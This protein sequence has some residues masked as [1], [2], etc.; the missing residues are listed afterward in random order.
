MALEC[1]V[2][3]SE[4]RRSEVLDAMAAH[5]DRHPSVHLLHEDR[6]WDANRT[7]FTL[8]GDSD[9]LLQ[10]LTGLAQDCLSY[11]DMRQ[12][13]GIHPRIGALDVCPIIPLHPDAE[14]EAHRTVAALAESF[15]QLG[16][17]GWFYAQSAVQE[18]FDLLAH[19]R[20][21]DYEGVAA[22]A[23][24]FDFGRY[25]PRFGAMALG[26]RP[27]LLAYNVNVKG[28]DLAQVK[29][30]AKNV[31]ASSLGGIPG[32]RAIGWD[33][34]EFGCLQVSCNIVDLQQCTPKMLFDRI[35][36]EATVL[37]GA[38]WG[39]EL[40]G[41]APQHAFRDF[42]STEDAVNYLGLSQ[43][44]PFNPSERILERV[45]ENL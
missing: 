31:R 30:I 36:K 27:F 45:L 33:T 41:M 16:V 22:R 42:P 14:N 37:G 2:N 10:A 32:I 23:N 8:V 4:G 43:V 9:G 26:V 24:T 38:L 15:A 21:G 34:P 1:V 13:A 28:L 25:E 17:G 29:T 20:K 5:L 3:V 6:G 18:G 35:A 19:V 44:V 7:V 12:H 11:L 39:S 40:I